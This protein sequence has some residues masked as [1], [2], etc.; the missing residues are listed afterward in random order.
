MKI[1]DGSVFLT[2][3]ELHGNGAD[4][5]GYKCIAQPNVNQSICV[6]RLSTHD[7]SNQQETPED[8]VVT[9][10]VNNVSKAML[11]WLAVQSIRQNV[12]EIAETSDINA[13]GLVELIW[14][15][16]E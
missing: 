15:G 7:T 9:Y 6:Y 10:T 13:N 3:T 4:Q 5:C 14:N 12:V 1:Q 16:L 11:L 2:L 8:M